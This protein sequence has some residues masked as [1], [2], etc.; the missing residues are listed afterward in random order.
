MMKKFYRFIPLFLAVTSLLCTYAYATD[1]IEGESESFSLSFG[2]G[3]LSFLDIFSSLFSDTINDFLV[4]VVNEAFELVDSL[5]LNL[6]NTAFY[7]EKLILSGV[8]T[9][10]TQVQLQNLYLFLYAFVSGVVVLKFLMKG[11]QIYILWRDGDAEVSPGGML[12]GVAQAGFAMVA[13]PYLY[14]KGVDIFLFFANGIMGRLGMATES[15]MHISWI[16]TLGAAGIIFIVFALIFFVLVFVLWIKLMI[17]G[18]QLLIMRLGFPFATVG[19]ID[20]DAALFKNYIQVF[21]K[22]AFTVVIQVTLMALAFRVIATLQLINLMAAIA[23]MCTALST[24]QLLQQFL[25]PSGG[26]GS[27]TQKAYGISMAVRATKMLFV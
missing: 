8:T 23:L 17:Q 25:L 15:L 18:F 1:A 11:S 12:V 4:D 21:F 26:G 19:L 14:D 5:M 27:L 9:V 3:G 22:Y 6:L 16:T 2:L 24:P 7:A 13:F 20:S 10:M